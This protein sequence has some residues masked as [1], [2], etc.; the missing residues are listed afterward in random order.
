MD[1]QENGS[2]AAR[3]ARGR[4]RGWTDKTAQ[5]TI[6]SLDRAMEV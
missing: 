6:K 2:G 3:R 1:S 4:P 5:N